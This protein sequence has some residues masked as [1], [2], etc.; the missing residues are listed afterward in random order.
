ML[1][2]RTLFAATVL[3]VLALDSAEAAPQ[4]IGY[5]DL[6]RTLNETKAGKAARDRLESEKKK[7]QGEIDRQQTALKKEFDDF[8]KQ[9]LVLK[10]DARMKKERELQD[11]YVALQQKFME[12]QQELSKSEAKLTR[13]ILE[14]AGKIIE[15]IAKS[16]GYSMIVEK[17]EGAVLFADPS[18]DITSELNTRLDSAPGG[19]KKGGK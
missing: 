10:D 5:V 15:D 12:L 18:N 6:Q 17:N 13:D 7:K 4:K 2:T 11:K 14:K 3:W 16:Q 19:G 1:I 8:E 9:K